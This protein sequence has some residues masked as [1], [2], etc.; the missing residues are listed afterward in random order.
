MSRRLRSARR[1]WAHA[2]CLLVPT[3]RAPRARRPCSSRRWTTRCCCGAPSWETCGP[4]RDAARHAAAGHRPHAPLQPR[5]C[6]PAA[7]PR[8]TRLA[9]Q[10][11]RLLAP[12]APRIR[13][14]AACLEPSP[15]QTLLLPPRACCAPLRRRFTPPARR[16]RSWPRS[17][18][19]RT[20][21]R[22]CCTKWTTAQ[23]RLAAWRFRSLVF[24]ARWRVRAWLT[25]VTCRQVRAE[26]VG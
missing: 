26:D 9:T 5:R 7:Q 22:R 10:R 4:A 19:C 13:S 15:A 6:A 24:G 25:L 21:R 2:S 18:A 1:V 20:R 11:T 23:A 12:P 8:T 16:S 17:S 3:R 14:C